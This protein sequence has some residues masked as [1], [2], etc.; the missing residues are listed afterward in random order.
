MTSFK[1]YLLIQML[2]YR[3][4]AFYLNKVCV[5][6]CVW[7]RQVFAAVSRLSLQLWVGATLVAV[8]RLP[9]LHWVPSLVVEAQWALE[10]K[11]QQ[12]QHMGSG[13]GSWTLKHR[14]SSHGPSRLSCPKTCVVFLDQRSNRYP[15]DARQSLNYWTT[16][17][18]P[19][20]VLKTFLL[21]C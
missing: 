16:R 1:Y 2:G 17:K 9:P 18:S 6:V 10:C 13:W 3:I 15:L 21:L 11:P 20:I 5:C 14:P 12:L 4:S 7:L 8:C 19:S